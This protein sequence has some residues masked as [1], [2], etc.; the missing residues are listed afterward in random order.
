MT[1]CTPPSRRVRLWIHRVTWIALSLALAGLLLP[2]AWILW[3]GRSDILQAPPTS[4]PAA[5]S[6]ALVLGTSPQGR[7]QTL[8]PFFEGRMDAAANL[9]HSGAAYHL[10]LSGDNRRADYNE[11]H[12]MREALRARG[13]PL[14]AMTLDYAGFRTLDSVVRAH[15]VFGLRSFLL[16]TDDFHL[17]RALFLAKA[18]GLNTKGFAS[19]PV[20][21][22][23][24]YKTRL[25]EW[26]SRVRAFYDIYLGKTQPHFLG[27]TILLPEPPAPHADL[28]SPDSTQPPLEKTE[29][30][31]P[32]ESHP[33]R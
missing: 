3:Q 13:V 33:N 1:V 9:F 7:R 5:P 8:N 20:A 14:A 24:S 18:E 32:P 31:E 19:K 30:P 2:N 6:V 26:G 12:A 17:P 25:R 28:S 29:R 10:L 21:W 11:P 16:I 27:K 4:R 15:R 23:R 22:S